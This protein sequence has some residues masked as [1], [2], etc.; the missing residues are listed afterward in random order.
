M[1][2][3]KPAVAVHAR[4]DRHV[5]AAPADRGRAGRRHRD[6]AP[7]RAGRARSRPSRAA[8]QGRDAGPTPSGSYAAWIRSIGRPSQTD[9]RFQVVVQ[10]PP[11]AKAAVDRRHAALSSGATVSCRHIAR[12][13]LARCRRARRRRTATRMAQ[14]EARALRLDGAADRQADDV[15]QQLHQQ[16]R[17]ATCRRRRSGAPSA[18]P[19]TTARPAPGWRAPRSRCSPR[20]A[21]N[22]SPALGRSWRV[23]KRKKRPARRCPGG[24]W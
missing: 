12:A 15:G 10:L 23:G 18:R 4:P 21:R 11:F 3:R 2:D 7:G 6:A 9:K 8:R 20:K 13:A 1:R 16:R 14:P 19:T 5:D 22:S 24:A 17:C